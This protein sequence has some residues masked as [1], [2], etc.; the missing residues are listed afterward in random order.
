MFGYVVPDKMNMYMKD[1]YRYRAFYCG[2]CKSCGKRCGQCMR[3]STNYD[4][5]F[6]NLLLH[7]VFDVEPEFANEGCILNPVKKKTIAKND[8][9]T[10]MAVDTNT[11]LMY[12]K[13]LDDKLDD[14]SVSKAIVR[15]LI[16]SNK[17][18]KAKRNLPEIDRLYETEM[19]NLHA[20]ERDGCDSLDRLADTFANMLKGSIKILTAD[21]Y[22]EPL[23]RL[24]YNIGKWVYIIDAVDDVDKDHKKSSFNPFIINYE[25]TTREK[26]VA[27][28]G[29]EAEKSLMYCYYAMRESFNE[30]K[31]N[32][33]DGVLTNIIWYG[34]LDRTNEVVRRTSKCKKIRI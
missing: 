3:L 28:R 4:I 15:K 21:K 23:G 24:M 31:F 14:R 26:F 5:T 10:E 22:S 17:Y 6:M 7:A 13:L 32:L 2:F 20:L 11:L 19:N 29:E 25:Y 12:Y 27:D 8:S 33:N 1:Y 34:I 18:K 9:I 16:V 30:L